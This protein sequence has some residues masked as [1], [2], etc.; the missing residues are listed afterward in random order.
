MPYSS[1]EDCSDYDDY[2]AGGCR[3][4]KKPVVTPK[5]RKGMGSTTTSVSSTPRSTASK[6]TP[7][8]TSS[9]TPSGAPS[10]LSGSVQSTPSQLRMS[11]SSKYLGELVEESKRDEDIIRNAVKDLKGSMAVHVLVV[12]HVDAGKSTTFG[13]L[14]LLTGNIDPHEA[15]KLTRLAEDM[16]KSSFGY[17]FLLDTDSEERS[18]G[19]TIDVCNHTLRIALP[20]LGEEL[21]EPRTFALQDCP[22]HRDFVPALISS[23]TRPDAAVLLVDAS[24]GEFEKGISTDGQTLEH[25]QLLMVFGI[26]TLIVAINKMDRSSWCEK[27]YNEIVTKLSTIIKDDVQFKGLLQFIPISGI[28]PDEENNLVPGQ[29]TKLPDWVSQGPSLAEALYRIQTNRSTSLVK[30][31]YSQP[32]LVLFDAQIEMLGGKRCYSCTCLVESGILK[33][34][35]SVVNIPSG[36]PFQVASITMFGEQRDNAV[37]YDVVTLNLFPD[38]RVLKPC[39]PCEKLDTVTVLSNLKPGSCFILTGVILDTDAI[40]VGTRFNGVT[41]TVR[42]KVK[43]LILDQQRGLGR[44]D[45]YDCYLGAN[46]IEAT[47]R[48]IDAQLRMDG[49]VERENPPIVGWKRYARLTLQLDSCVVAREFADSKFLGRVIL[50]GDNKTVAIGFVERISEK[51]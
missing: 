6:V 27:R 41:I 11:A 32:T 50:R 25:V 38:S 16:G 5:G 35:D 3:L 42:I 40:K 24:Q 36:Y 51:P 1:D 44:G 22:G 31:K 39:T 13:H 37:A 28:G 23:A 15:E 2:S 9:N 46:R 49:S 18:R 20:T 7:G 14:A 17:A 30:G 26:K 12:G 33:A 4:Y 43:V 19:V 21:A 29:A 8:K 48:K 47:V 34:T 45:M 10:C